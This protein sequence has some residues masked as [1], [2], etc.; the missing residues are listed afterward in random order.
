MDHAAGLVPLQL[1]ACHCR[2]SPLGC[3]LFRLQAAK[4]SQIFMIC[5]CQLGSS[6]GYQSLPAPADSSQY[7]RLVTPPIGQME[8]R[9]RS[10]QLLQASR[11]ACHQQLLLGEFA[12]SSPQQTICIKTPTSQALPCLSGQSAKFTVKQ[13]EIFS[14]SVRPPPP[15]QPPAQ[16]TSH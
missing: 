16:P 15:H 7:R 10:N 8:N 1:V 14:G 9:Q 13:A 4:G 2:Q 5:C 11:Q 3:Q 12:A 6:G